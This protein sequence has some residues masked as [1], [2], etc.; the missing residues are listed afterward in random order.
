MHKGKLGFMSFIRQL[1]PCFSSEVTMLK[2]VVV[3]FGGVMK[4]LSR[5]REISLCRENQQAS[6]VPVLYTIEGAYKPTGQQW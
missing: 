6:V 3:A 4:Y 2:P 5:D 1:S